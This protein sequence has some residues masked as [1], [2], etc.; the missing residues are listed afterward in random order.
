MQAFE[1]H[2]QAVYQI[3][4]VD[5]VLPAVGRCLDILGDSAEP[6]LDRF[7][8]SL[9][10]QTRLE[11]ADILLTQL[12]EQAA[13]RGHLQKMLDVRRIEL[14]ALRKE[15]DPAVA[16]LLDRLT[17]LPDALARDAFDILAAHLA[18]ADTRRLDGLCATVLEQGRGKE[19]LRRNAAYR[20]L[21]NAA[22]ARA[23]ADIAS[24]LE[25]CLNV[26]LP[27]NLVRALYQRY[28][29][30]VVGGPDPDATRA[31]MTFGR[32]L[33]NRVEDA[34]AQAGITTTLLDAAFVLN[35]FDAA[36]GMIEGGIPNR[37]ETWH[38]MAA[39]KLRAHAALQNGDTRAAIQH[40]RDFMAVIAESYEEPEV[41]PTTG[42]AHTRNM[43]LGRNAKRIGDLLA[44]EDTVASEDAYREARGYYEQA[45]DEV[46]P[47][48]EEMK[49]IRSEM[50]AIPDAASPQSEPATNTTAP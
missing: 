24:R 16:Y 49:L 10:R 45:L 36:L 9:L 1:W 32:T 2:F 47:G 29:Y 22:E 7:I 6:V 26:S 21:K 48:S 13:D 28:F 18:A 19:L 15:W 43:L 44:K 17:D 4:G 5:G 31:I 3:S 34:D 11:D 23:P 42:L 50:A 25:T 38:K 39:S 41:D 30:S 46:K 20:W 35:D 8:R 37:S 14:L 40:F 12:R 27:V 33:R